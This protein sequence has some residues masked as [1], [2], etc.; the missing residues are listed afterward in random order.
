VRA[1]ALASAILLAS[2]SA[3]GATITIV[4]ANT[5]TGGFN[6]P[7]PAAPVGGNTGTTVGAQRLIAFQHAA[8]IWGAVLES[9][10]EIR[11]QASFTALDCTSDSATLG[12]TG[13]IQ[14]VDNFD[15]APFSDTWYVTALA[16]RIAGTDVIPGAPNSNADDIRSRFN[17]SLGSAGC[18]DGIGWYYGLDN[19]HGNQVDLVSVVLHELAHGLGFVTLVGEDG[20]EFIDQPDVFERSIL[21]VETGRR[22]NDMTESERGVSALNGRNVVFSGPRSTAE[23]PDFLAPGTPFLNVLAP[24][25]AAGRY[26][27]GT[28]EFGPPLSAAGVTGDLAAAQDAADTAGPTATD[29][30]SAITNAAEIAGKISLVDRGTCLFTEKV[31]NAQNA[32]ALAVVVAD[33]EAGTPPGMLGAEPGA[34]GSITI[35]SVRVTMADGALLRAQL[36]A[37]VRVSLL[38]DPSV[39]SGA[40]PGG[41]PLLFA[42][43]PYQG[44]SS[45]SHFDDIATPNLLMEPN[46]SGDLEHE[47]D[48]TLP[49]L[50]DLGWSDDADG[51]GIPDAADNCPKAFNPDQA[52]ANGDGYGDPCD[53]VFTPPDLPARPKHTLPPRP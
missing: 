44:G 53:R 29:A 14:V 26:S 50:L 52:D 31:Q 37:G 51:D 24:A 35:P 5:G 8:D 33:H 20:S 9:D 47:V 28:A 30:C 4:N 2:A 34:G 19:N 21:D 43:N 13:T 16:S 17:S 25:A 22:W 42:T 45:I 48:L 40:D 1:A 7:T 6:D 27:V 15:N 10:V 41:R 12:S 49:L 46:I 18:F 23:A 38:L 11:V 36:P 39:L 32:G 3:R